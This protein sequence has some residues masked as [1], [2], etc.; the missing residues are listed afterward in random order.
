MLDPAAADALA[1]PPAAALVEAC[2]AGDDEAG[3]GDDELVLHPTISAAAAAIATP[4]V[5]MRMRLCQIMVLT[6]PSTMRPLARDYIGPFLCERSSNITISLLK[7]YNTAGGEAEVAR[8]RDTL[9]CVSVAAEFLRNRT[10]KVSRNAF[11]VPA[12]SSIIQVYGPLSRADD[13]S[14][15]C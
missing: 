10:I 7:G 12:V 14:F 13:N 3:A 15:L 6:A 5:A 4:L 1:D 2:A 9:D 11:S 8:G